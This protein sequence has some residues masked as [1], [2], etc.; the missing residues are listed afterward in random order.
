MKTKLIEMTMKLFGPKI[1]RQALAAAGGFFAGH[2]MA[3]DENSLFSIV[4]GLLAWLIASVYSY[5]AKAAP[6]AEM[7]DQIS[8]IAG[9]LAS[10]AIAFLAGWLQSMG[11][12]GMI[13]DS[14]GIS[15]FLANYGLSKVSRP[16]KAKEAITGR[17]ASERPPGVTAHEMG[18]GPGKF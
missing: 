2:G 5:F 18:N 15:L 1:I 6:D 12:A 14:F 3:V 7:K 17:A 11:Y 8:K 4:G 13:D 10:Q 16:D 9:A